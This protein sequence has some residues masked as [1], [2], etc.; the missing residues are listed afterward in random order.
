MRLVLRHPQQ[1]EF[2]IPDSRLF[3]RRIERRTKRFMDQQRH[4]GI[5]FPGGSHHLGDEMCSTRIPALFKA[6]I[7]VILVKR[8]TRTLEPIEEMSV[9]DRQDERRYN[10]EGCGDYEANEF[11]VSDD[12]V[13][14]TSSDDAAVQPWN[15]VLGKRKRRDTEPLYESDQSSGDSDWRP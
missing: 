10:H 1:M 2:V 4:D 13:N 7:K 5:L 6:W 15:V 3:R 11:L 8:K 9:I 14:Y 12:S